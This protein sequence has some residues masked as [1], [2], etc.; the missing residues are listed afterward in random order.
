M[1]VLLVDGDILVYR[2][3]FSCEVKRYKA[4]KDDQVFFEGDSYRELKY[5][6]EGQGFKMKDFDI[7]SEATIKPVTVLHD[8][9]DK[10]MS[11]IAKRTGGDS[12]EIYLSSSECFRHRLATTKAYKSGR[13]A[14]PL[15]YLEAKRYLIQK[16][17]ATLLEDMEADDMLSIR[18]HELREDGVP[19][20]LV[21]IDKDLHQVP[22]LHYN[23]VK[24]EWT[25]ITYL[26]GQRKLFIQVLTGDTTDS[27]PGLPGVGEKT[28]EK[29]LKD[30]LTIEQM[31]AAVIAKYKMMEEA[32]KIEKGF[33]FEQA[34][35]VFILPRLSC[36]LN[37]ELEVV[38]DYADEIEGI[39][40]FIPDTEGV[41]HDV[42]IKQ[43]EQAGDS[44]ESTEQPNT[45]ESGVTEPSGGSEGVQAVPVQDERGRVHSP[46][47]FRNT[48][49]RY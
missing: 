7:Q 13:A 3:A 18:M 36:H 28:A 21:S 40:V 8:V 34:N 39:E 14:R 25:T 1:A 41:E 4:V 46:V 38:D 35:L 24:D 27:I 47:G 44:P 6:V 19:C 12:W 10:M 31:K 20:V 29:V 33:L 37:E 2:A 11:N 5:L 48:R 32:G 42:Q 30:C 22:G 43:P 9:I 45:T 16:F 15:H 17:G 23:N 26:E 49:G